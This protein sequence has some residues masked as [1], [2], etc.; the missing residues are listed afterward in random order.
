MSDLVAIRP[1]VDLSGKVAVITG[2]GS[3]FGLALALLAAR[4]GMKVALADADP[5]ALAAVQE[6]LRGQSIETLAECV[7]QADLVALRDFAGRIEKELGPPWLVCNSAS[8]STPEVNLWGVVNG[9][10]VF[11]PGVVLRGAGH[12]VNI[13]SEEVFGIRGAAVDIAVRHAILGLS[14]ALYRELDSMRSRVGVTVVLP[15]SM[16]VSLTSS[17]STP[18]LVPQG[19]LRLLPVEHIAEQIFAAIQV[20]QFWVSTHDCPRPSKG[21]GVATLL[22]GT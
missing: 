22:F 9:V 21:S 7:G 6:V 20:R 11:T 19:S 18:M 12:I 1:Q 13:A 15:S 5:I 8:A 2:A 16:D 4:R 17:V 14:E 10:Q 3:E